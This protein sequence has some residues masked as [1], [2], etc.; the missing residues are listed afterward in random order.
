MRATTND[1]YKDLYTAEHIPV[2]RMAPGGP[3]EIPFDF[4]LPAKFPVPQLFSATVL[5][6]GLRSAAFPQ[7][8][9]GG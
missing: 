7:L 1:V 6:P 4:K 8:L 9:H 2:P 3:C 5:Q